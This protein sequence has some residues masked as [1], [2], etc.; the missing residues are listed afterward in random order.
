M[1][2]RKCRLGEIKQWLSK[3][4]TIELPAI[5]RGFVWK[6]YQI[7]NL[8]DS[9]FRQ[10]P[11]GSFLLTATGKKL[12]LIDG[13]QRATALALGFF[14]P[15]KDES[16]HLGNVKNL[17]VIWM[18]VL[19]VSKTENSVFV[20]RVVTRSHPWGYQL[21]NNRNV[22][23]VSDRRNSADQMLRIVND[24]EKMEKMYTLLK[25]AQR[26]PYDARLPIP[27]CFLL[28][29]LETARDYADWKRVVEQKCQVIPEQY[30]PKHLPTD[31]QYHSAIETCD[32]SD[33]YNTIK[34]IEK[35]YIIPA[36][37]VNNQ[38]ILKSE[39]ST[40]VNP[41]LFVR[42]NSGGTQL[43]GEELIYSIYKAVW[44]STKA[45][46]ESIA[47][48]IIQPSKIITLASRLV[49]SKLN[50][51]FYK[52]ISLAQFQREIANEEFKCALESLIGKER[53]SSLR[54]LI[55]KSI[56]I[57]KYDGTIPDIIVKRFIKDSTDGFLL[58][59]NWLLHNPDQSIDFDLKARI[60]SRLYTN[61]WFG[62]LGHMVRQLWK[63]SSDKSFWT[64]CYHNEDYL[65]QKHLVNPAA[66]E[67]FLLRRAQEGNDFSISQE[68]AIWEEWTACAPRPESMSEENYNV[69]MKDGW[70]NYLSRLLNNKYLILL[71]QR[72]YI[73]RT[74][75]DYNQIEDLQDTERP[76]DWDHIYPQSW[77]YY[78][79]EIDKRTSYW[80]WRIGNYRAM[81]LTDNRSENAHL[82]PAERFKTTD[83]DYF[84]KENDLD[85]WSKL[86]A[87]HKYIKN[88]D[89]EFVMIHAKAIIIRSVNI[90][91]VFYDMF[92]KYQ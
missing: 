72:D 79:R 22:L 63:G 11:M 24:N 19:P 78:Q 49:L 58:L 10:Y 38:L 57:L 86:T 56:D 68:D 2:L 33:L 71:A 29:A 76:W 54:S 30:H 62:D 20:F 5:Q 34:Q 80:E 77:V 83:D 16:L 4:S 40:E 13:Q 27:L 48:S 44:P 14:N 88:S 3:D 84:I 55:D 31:N 73:N 91:R 64:I 15:W 75:K 45:L 7:E 37:I 32:L 90:Y 85:Y 6:P 12:M 46:V 51:A 81:S 50:N 43:E 92:A 8:W 70:N 87:E 39:E 21:N 52:G 9:V 26:L 74:F 28:E 60:C 65:A 35:D 82:S 59:L 69:L 1:K 17:P 61:Y 67:S 53:D 42:I 23:S 41:T 66:L 89:P 25:P 47:S 18:D 36:I